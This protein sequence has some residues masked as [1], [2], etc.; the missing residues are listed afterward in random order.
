M[1]PFPI[2]ERWVSKDIV[3]ERQDNTVSANTLKVTLNPKNNP[4]TTCPYLLSTNDDSMNSMID[5]ED[6]SN[7]NNNDD[8]NSP[9]VSAEK[10]KST[11]MK[12]SKNH[13][14]TVVTPNKATHQVIVQKNTQV[15]MFP[16]DWKHDKSWSVFGAGKRACPGT[17]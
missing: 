2:L 1:H 10:L 3:V 12:E 14:K 9:A 5:D 16:S 8:S 15:V 13:T 7:D 6:D 11:H 17:H 4:M